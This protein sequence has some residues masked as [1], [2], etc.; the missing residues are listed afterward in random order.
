MTHI[1]LVNQ[2]P[3]QVSDEQGVLMAR[4]VAVGLKHLGQ[5]WGKVV[6]TCAYVP[7]VDRMPAGSKPLYI[8]KNPDVPNALGWHDVD[9]KG[10]AFGKVFVEP[11]LDNGGSVIASGATEDSNSVLQTAG[12]EADELD[13]DELVGSWEVMPDG[14]TLLAKEA[15][16]PCEDRSKRVRL[17]SGESAWC[18]DFVTPQY[19]RRVGAPQGPLTWC[20][21]LTEPFS[22]TPGGYQ[23][24]WSTRGSE[25]QVFPSIVQG[26]G[27][28]AVSVEHG[29]DG[30]RILWGPQ[31]P[32]W[33]KALKRAKI[34]RT[35]RRV[36]LHLP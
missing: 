34:S 9:D 21:A 16:D 22:M 23:I 32:E 3:Q 25:H 24:Q 2:S 14:H 10:N 33:K 26:H 18:S 29:D 35:A 36:Q 27:H 17:T 30:L 5:A 20:S 28:G 4:F 19:F 13:L 8:F 1:V 6:S 12:H 15:S 31:V 7:S 11:T